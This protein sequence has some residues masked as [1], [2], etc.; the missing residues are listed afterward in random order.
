[1]MRILVILVGSL[2]GATVMSHIGGIPQLLG[3]TIAALL[4]WIALRKQAP[5][6]I[7]LAILLITLIAFVIGVV[8][9]K[10]FRILM[11]LFPN[12]PTI[13]DQRNQL[14]YLKLALT[15]TISILFLWAWSSRLNP[16]HKTSKWQ[17][18]TILL[19]LF[20]IIM[21]VLIYSSKIILGE[22]MH[23]INLKSI[24]QKGLW[25]NSLNL[26]LIIL[27][28]TIIHLGNLVSTFAMGVQHI[29]KLQQ[30][31]VSLRKPLKLNIPRFTRRIFKYYFIFWFAWYPITMLLIQFNHPLIHAARAKDLVKVEKIIESGISSDIANLSLI[32]AF[33]LH[34]PN[35]HNPDATRP[36]KLIVQKLIRSGADVNNRLSRQQILHGFFDS[37]HISRGEACSPDGV[38]LLKFL[39]NAGANVNAKNRHGETPLIVTIRNQDCLEY[40]KILLAA[41][42]RVN[43]IDKKGSSALFSRDTPQAIHVEAMRLLIQAGADVNVMNYK[44]SLDGDLR[45]NEIIQYFQRNPSITSSASN[46]LDSQTPLMQSVMA[47]LNRVDQSHKEDWERVKMLVE[48]GADINLKNQYG[49]SALSLARKIGHPGLSKFLA[50]KAQT[51]S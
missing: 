34:Y 16:I 42:A 45:L 21:P 32:E 11:D 20:G 5:P 7:V 1:M 6:R 24:I 23:Q 36:I 18:I 17:S 35:I 3:S 47:F 29:I 51:S 41:G 37:H 38:D 9:V 25:K 33:H 22:W 30:N 12:L 43:E 46:S 49:E 15:P 13:L 19:I 4:T 39:I 8:N 14:A 44:T 27:I 50:E 10:S 40:A 26:V 2:V 48:A 31:G 28:I